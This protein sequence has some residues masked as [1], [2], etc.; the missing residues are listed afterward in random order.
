[1]A[2]AN[3]DGDRVFVFVAVA[4][5]RCGID[6]VGAVASRDDD[7]TCSDCVELAI[8]AA[9][10]DGDRTAAVGRQMVV[11]S[12][13]AVEDDFVV[14]AE[15]QVDACSVATGVNGGGGAVVEGLVQI[16]IDVQLGVACDD[17]VGEGAIVRVAVHMA[18]VAVGDEVTA[19]GGLDVEGVGVVC[20]HQ[21]GRVAKVDVV[22]HEVN[23]VA[24]C[25]TV[26]DVHVLR[27]AA[28]D[29]GFSAGANAR[30]GEAA[31]RGLVDT[32]LQ[33]VKPAFGDGEGFDVDCATEVQNGVLEIGAARQVGIGAVT[34]RVGVDIGQ[35][36][37]DHVLDVQQCCW[38]GVIA[39]GIDFEGVGLATTCI[40]VCLMQQLETTGNDRVVVTGGLLVL[41]RIGT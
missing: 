25:G 29:G 35:V 20:H 41:T 12:G 13:G 37:N 2:I 17:E 16:A 21:L 32:A 8:A 15:F 38:L 33:A 40:D 1:M 11:R 19:T 28:V 26:V 5:H 24:L 18:E 4:A 27:E 10:H 7:V 9:C 30:H 31:R 22:Q 23:A 3:G 6:F 36:V 14:V 39:F 34:S